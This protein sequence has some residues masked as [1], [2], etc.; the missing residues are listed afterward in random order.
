[1]LRNWSCMVVFGYHSSWW[2]CRTIHKLFVIISL[3]RG[4]FRLIMADPQTMHLIAR[5]ERGDFTSAAVAASAV[6]S[7]YVCMF[8]NAFSG[9]EYFEW[10][11]NTALLLLLFAIFDSQRQLTF[12][13]SNFS[14]I[15]FFLSVFAP[16]F[17]ND[18]CCGFV[19]ESTHRQNLK[20]PS[21][22]LCSKRT[23]CWAR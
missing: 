7:L 4:G 9:D 8:F 13:I 6:V 5:F 3:E 11:S 15:I 22:I 16:Q 1:M 14:S 12:S 10:L 2:W 20:S 19:S 17:V 23:E 18:I 21:N